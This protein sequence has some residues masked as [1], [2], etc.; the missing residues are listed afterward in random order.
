LLARTT[1]RP[2]TDETP[3]RPPR[4]IGEGTAAARGE[5][6]REWDAAEWKSGRVVQLLWKEADRGELAGTCSVRARGLF[7]HGVYS[8]S[9]CRSFLPWVQRVCAVPGG[10]GDTQGI[11]LGGER[12]PGVVST[13][14]GADAAGDATRE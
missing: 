3:G 13:G 7:T 2:N 1:I 11:S 10:I 9:S 12:T 6:P 5:E 14:V 8:E 4:F